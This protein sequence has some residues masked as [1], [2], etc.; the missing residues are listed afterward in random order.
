MLPVKSSFVTIFDENYLAQGLSMISS[1]ERTTPT[2]Q[3]WVVAA[4]AATLEAVSRNASARVSVVPL[5][6]VENPE[7]L[8]V[9]SSRSRVEYYWTLTPFLP[10]FLFRVQED[11]EVATYVDADMYFFRSAHEVLHE[12]QDD[13]DAAVMLTPHDYLPRYD[14]T[15]VSGEFCVQFMPFR[16]GTSRNILESWQSKC[17]DW[18]F[19]RPEPGRFGD[20]KYLDVWPQEFGS[21]VRIQQD[22]GLLG[23]PWNAD[24][25]S[26][27]NLVAYH[28]HGLRRIG[29]RL[30]ALHPGYRIST[31]FE[32]DVY[33]PYM[34]EFGRFGN[35][36][37]ATASWK[38]GRRTVLRV[39]ADSLRG[40]PLKPAF[41]WAQAG[42]RPRRDLPCVDPKPP[43]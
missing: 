33:R 9:K 39:M 31:S 21:Q 35:E 8:R 26:V 30:T 11:C 6:E 16:R 13:P 32:R 20:Q 4:D 15:A 14:Q 37:P 38:G 19:Q 40:F 10:D 22:V 42:S 3:I 43:L 27:S 12:F 28:F 25:R 41:A 1:L 34:Q 2:A 23:A 29:R 7:L 24:M 17:L 36:F 5:V 18:C